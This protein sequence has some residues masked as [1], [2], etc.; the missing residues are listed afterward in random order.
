MSRERVEML[1]P[2]DAAGAASRVDLHELIPKLN[3]FRTILRRPR[4][5]KA[6]SDL[7]LSLM[8]EAELEHRLRELVIM[9]IG[10]VT[11]SE[12]EWAQ[13]WPLAQEMFGCTSEELVALRSWRGSDLF[14]ER[15]RIVLGAT[16]ELL[17]TG[18]LS[19]EGWAR[20]E[21]ALGREASIDLV[22]AV[23]TWRLVSIL[24]RGLRVPLEEGRDS[25]PPDGKASPAEARGP[26]LG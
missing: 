23:A 16:D 7:I 18:D 3:I 12:Y 22:S 17:E 2:E 25:W 13:H 26:V 5:A 15:D 14:D 6:V 1:S 4:T 21:A 11:G 9:R 8:F 20:C 24:A 19:D 10:W